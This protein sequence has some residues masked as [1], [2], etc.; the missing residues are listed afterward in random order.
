M[1]DHYSRHW[2]KGFED[3]I[4]A[5]SISAEDMLPY[6]YAVLHYPVYHYDRKDDPSR[7][8]RTYI[9]LCRYFGHWAELGR[10]LLNLHANFMTAAPYPLKRNANL[11][12]TNVMLRANAQDGEQCLI[13]IDD[14]TTLSGIPEAECRYKFGNRSALN[15]FLTS[16]KR[17]R[18]LTPPISTKMNA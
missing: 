18:R 2:G 1:N 14:Q 15:G 13:Y 9:L 6:A 4:G 8:F 11:Q 17:A 10:K 12:Q 7:E 5:K 3:A 16:T